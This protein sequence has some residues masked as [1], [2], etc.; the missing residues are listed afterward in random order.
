MENL[1]KQWERLAER[2]HE[3][4]KDAEGFAYEH[5]QA[6]ASTLEMCA[7]QLRAKMKSD[8]SNLRLEKHG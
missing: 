8:P 6:S 4:A 3:K 5:L 7:E 2:Y 1:I